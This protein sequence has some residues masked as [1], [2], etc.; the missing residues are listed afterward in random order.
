MCRKI[1]LQRSKPGGPRAVS[2][3]VV[4]GKGLQKQGRCLAGTGV[5]WHRP[6]ER[7]GVDARLKPSKP[8]HQP[9]ILAH[10]PPPDLGEA[11]SLHT[12]TPISCSR[13]SCSKNPGWRDSGAF[14]GPGQTHSFERRFGLGRTPGS[15]PV[16]SRPSLRHSPPL[17]FPLSAGLVRVRIAG[18][19]ELHRLVPRRAQGNPNVESGGCIQE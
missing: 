13:N 3:A 7:N 4:P 9:S 16:L 11:V 14:L 12:H 19:K 2:A 18:D 8:K 1:S 10:V 6:E 5:T 15:I 17:P